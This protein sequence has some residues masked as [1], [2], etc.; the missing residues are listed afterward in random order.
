MIRIYKNTGFNITR[1]HADNEFQSIVDEFDANFKMVFNF[2]S[3]KEH[4]PEAERNNRLIKE[5]VRATFHCL[6]FV[7]IPKVMIQVMVMDNAKKMIFFPIRWEK[8]FLI[9]R[10]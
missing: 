9:S 5:R 6:P 7:K 8:E 2:T 1:I 4:V 10:S 3:A